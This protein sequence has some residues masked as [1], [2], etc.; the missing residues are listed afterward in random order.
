M[1]PPGRLSL[2]LP[3]QFPRIYLCQLVWIYEHFVVFVDISTADAETALNILGR[4]IPTKVILL[5]VVSQILIIYAARVVAVR[6][7]HFII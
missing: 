2:V 7:S 3:D 1:L 5:I 4:C 6:I